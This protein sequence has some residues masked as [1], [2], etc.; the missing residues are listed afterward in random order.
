[1]HC[2]CS[3]LTLGFCS[4]GGVRV[5]LSVS[6]TLGRHSGAELAPALLTE[7]TKL[8]H[9]PCNYPLITQLFSVR[10][11]NCQLPNTVKVSPLLQ[12]LST[13]THSWFIFYGCDKA[14]MTKSSL[15][16]KGLIC[17]TMT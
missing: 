9:P 17:L 2:K 15:E 4:L 16:K 3:S 1:M 11:L 6:D 5:E 14:G 13:V 8:T 10:L 12:H 7:H